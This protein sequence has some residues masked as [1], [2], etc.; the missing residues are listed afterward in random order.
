LGYISLFSAQ[1]VT[2]ED[3]MAARIER[4]HLWRGLLTSSIGLAHFAMPQRFEPLNVTLGFA[5]NTRKH[6]Y[7]NGTIETAI[8]FTM[9]HP[10]TRRIT[11]V[12]ALGYTGYL[13]ANFVRAKRSPGGKLLPS[14][15]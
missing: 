1:Q 12:A 6:V 2:T 11:P 14:T 9:I 5:R 10:A 7:I 3:A 8:G 4:A 13:A 15:C